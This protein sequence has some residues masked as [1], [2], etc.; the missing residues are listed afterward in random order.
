MRLDLDLSPQLVLYPGPEQ[1]VLLQDLEGDDV[2]G[3]LL[4]GQVHR[5][6]LAFAEGQPDLEVRQA[7][8]L[9]L[10]GVSLAAPVP[11]VLQPNSL[12]TFRRRAGAARTLSS[13]NN[14]QDAIN[15]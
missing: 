13:A 6:E 2:F 9:A 15:L 12:W 5:P 7:P 8:V 4:P 10:L 3:L 11:R 1:L 14:K